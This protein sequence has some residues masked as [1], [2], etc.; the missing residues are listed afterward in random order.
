MYSRYNLSSS[1]RTNVRN[2]KLF[3]VKTVVLLQICCRSWAR[4]IRPADKCIG[5][6]HRK[7]MGSLPVLL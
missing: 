6:M 5:S 3:Q 1:I 2:F 4:S 7:T